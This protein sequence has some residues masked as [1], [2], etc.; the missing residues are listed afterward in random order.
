MLQSQNS[1]CTGQ[2][3]KRSNGMKTSPAAKQHAK[4][5][6]KMTAKGI[7]ISIDA[8]LAMI[9]TIAFIGFIGI[10]LQQEEATTTTQATTNLSQ[11]TDDAFTA[12]DKSGF[13]AYQLVDRYSEPITAGQREM[14]ANAIDTNAKKMLPENI[15]MKVKIK[16]YV[17]PS[18]QATLNICKS[19]TDLTKF[20]K[21]FPQGTRFPKNPSDLFESNVEEIPTNKEVTHGRTIQILRQSIAAAGP[22]GECEVINLK[23]EKN[24]QKTAMLDELP[25]IDRLLLTE[26]IVDPS[27]YIACH[28]SPAPL[29]NR[30]PTVTAKMR[31]LARQPV[32]IMLAMDESGSMA[33][34]DMANCF[35]ASS[36]TAPACTC[37]QGNCP[38]GTCQKKQKSF[39]DG[40]CG[41]EPGDT[42]TGK[43][44][45]CPL[46]GHDGEPQHT[47][48]INIPA[49]SFDSDTI[50]SRVPDGFN[51]WA[52]TTTF[53]SPENTKWTCGAIPKIRAKAP[54][55]K[56]FYRESVSDG[57]LSTYYPDTYV[58]LSVYPPSGS[59][60]DVIHY[61]DLPANKIW[62]IE[63]WSNKDFPPTNL[64]RTFFGRI[65]V[66][67]SKC[68]SPSST[69]G[70]AEGT[71]E[72]CKPNLSTASPLG[73][74]NIPTL[75]SGQTILGMSISLPWTPSTYNSP[76]GCWPRLFIKKSGDPFPTNPTAATKCTSDSCG[77]SVDISSLGNQYEV[78]VWTDDTIADIPTCPA[79]GIYLGNSTFYVSIDDPG[80]LTASLSTAVAKGK[81]NGVDCSITPTNCDLK[82]ESTWSHNLD[83]FNIGTNDHYIGIKAR[84][85]G[86][87]G[88]LFNYAGACTE[89]NKVLEGDRGP[90][91]RIR[92]PDNTTV[93]TGWWDYCYDDGS[94]STTISVT[95]PAGLTTGDYELEGW[96]DGGNMNF[97]VDWNLQRVDVA[98]KSAKAFIEGLSTYQGMNWTGSDL[99]GA[100]AYSN[101]IDEV[102]DVQPLTNLRDDV[103]T[104]LNGLSPSGQTATADA[105]AKA[106]TEL[107]TGAAGKMKIMILLTDGKANICSGGAA[108]CTESKA[109]EDAI[110][111]ATIARQQGITVYA[112]GFADEGALR[113]GGYEEKLK[114]LAK[115]KLDVGESGTD[116]CAR[117]DLGGA[118][119]EYCGK[120]YWA[121]GGADLEAIF[122]KIIGELK[123]I[124]GAVDEIIFPFP[125]GMEIVD[126]DISDE[127][128][129]QIGKFGIWDDDTGDWLTDPSD[130][131]GSV[132][133]DGLKWPDG[134]ARNPKYLTPD[135][136]ITDES[137]GRMLKLSNE[138]CSGQ[139]KVNYTGNLWFAVQFDIKLPCNG[140]YCKY[141]YVLLPPKDPGASED[142]LKNPH[143][144]DEGG[145]VIYPWREPTTTGSCDTSPCA[146]NY[147]KVPFYYID[148]GIKFNHGRVVSGS[149]ALL[150]LTIQNN[151]HYDVPL[152]ALSAAK[153]K[154]LVNEAT[155]PLTVNCA[156]GCALTLPLKSPPVTVSSGGDYLSL[157]NMTLCHSK[158]TPCSPTATD[159][160]TEAQITN[161]SV[162]GTGSIYAQLNPDGSILECSENNRAQIICETAPKLKFYIIDYYTW[163]K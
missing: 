157:Q 94:C 127:P 71:G 86:N 79:G 90:K 10:G 72:E 25:A 50:Y 84:V 9:L 47:D 12:L 104:F 73:I 151:G 17:P 135:C 142:S 106:M 55:D 131:P 63:A 126:T 87:P 35:P 92:K 148:L 39:N 29:N 156:G 46:A 37:I 83:K 42:C 27:N 96:A 160:D 23:E 147:L 61:N 56:I 40:K 102:T 123:N 128:E 59:Y 5:W 18:D 95:P 117:S 33:E 88:P 137:G 114:E 162:G 57:T 43:G 121:K 14:I 60:N 45:N 53:T 82:T 1:F 41:A 30:E 78:Y 6:T 150:D 113:S 140:P 110:K 11:A 99:I 19:T 64:K 4:L 152:T 49:A 31:D 54:N 118:T 52:L 89:A 8:L 139:Q 103:K 2:G 132:W 108:D 136:W 105:I 93:G 65:T 26:V 62:N 133:P 16:E 145:T 48:W 69:E 22:T 129:T 124:I 66:P 77:F 36:C 91:F 68:L 100:V 7:A 98:K 13:L 15:G 161:V 3:N 134:V 141:E 44:G 51:S 153:T 81:C 122:K 155:P 24:K 116:Y 146:N 28:E 144:S 149:S 34:Y 58:K 75:F 119:G 20:D 158:P 38:I 97:T 130:L 120:Y 143:V 76:S 154:F 112:I 125:A 74:V 80:K 163:V 21:C 111:M 32:A 70:K 115:N 138:T 85:S 67:W 109:I 159:K 107:Q 101:K